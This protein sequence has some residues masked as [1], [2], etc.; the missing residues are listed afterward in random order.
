[1]MATGVRAEEVGFQLKY[2]KQELRKCVKEYSGKD[3]KKGLDAM[4][5]KIVKH[6]AD[7]DNRLLQVSFCNTGNFEFK[8]TTRLRSE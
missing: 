1:M 5:H 2:S 4:Y 7:N 3:V 6:T 8:R